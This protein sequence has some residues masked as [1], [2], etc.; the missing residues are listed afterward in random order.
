MTTSVVYSTPLPRR[1][2]IAGAVRGDG[3]RHRQRRTAPA[4][5]ARPDTPTWCTDAAASRDNRPMSR[6][7][8]LS[9]AREDVAVVAEMTADLRA[10]DHEVW[11][12]QDLG[13]GQDWWDRD[14]RPDPLVRR[15]RPRSQR[16]FSRVEGVHG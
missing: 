3:R 11:L 5:T 14:P 8:L 4:L 10:L 9:Y 13:G 12:D 1:S 16:G 7:I 2:V 6:Q 15:V